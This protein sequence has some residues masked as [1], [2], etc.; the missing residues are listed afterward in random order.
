MRRLEE[1]LVEQRGSVLPQ[2]K[3]MVMRDVEFGVV[4]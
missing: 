3:R 1:S 4:Q 2:A